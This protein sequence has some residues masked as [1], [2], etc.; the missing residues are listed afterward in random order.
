MPIRDRLP[1]ALLIGWLVLL[2]ACAP[3]TA[4]PRASATAIPTATV[5]TGGSSDT[6]QGHCGA[7]ASAGT[8]PAAGGS[9][10]GALAP[11]FRQEQALACAVIDTSDL[12]SGFERTDLQC[13]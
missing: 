1:V 7:S 13:D 3:R 2:S 5:I 6:Q 12:P 10:P 4:D 9:Q 8:T 11:A